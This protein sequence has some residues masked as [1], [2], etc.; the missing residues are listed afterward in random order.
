MTAKKKVVQKATREVVVGTILEISDTMLQPVADILEK[1]I[2][3][4]RTIKAVRFPDLTAEQY[5]Y[6]AQIASDNDI[7]VTMISAWID[8]GRLV[9]VVQN[10]AL[11]MIARRQPGYVSIISNAVYPGDEFEMDM[12]TGT[13]SKH[14][15]HPETME[16]DKNPLGAYSILKMEGKEPQSKWVY[17]HEYN[18]EKSDIWKKKKSALIS[19]CSSSVLLREAFGLSGLYGEEEIP[20]QSV[21]DRAKK[22]RQGLGQYIVSEGDPTVGEV[23]WEEEVDNTFR[24]KVA[25]FIA[26]PK[27]NQVLAEGLK[28]KAEDPNYSEAQAKKDCILI[29]QQ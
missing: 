28:K 20:Q 8:E 1:T 9:T 13:I 19:K 26:D 24:K 7:P 22:A 23:V 18:Q 4:V 6:V 21:S 16:I 15:I 25:E 14:V 12:A 3:E 17:W 5:L 29:D 11:L 10:E 2:Q 27:S